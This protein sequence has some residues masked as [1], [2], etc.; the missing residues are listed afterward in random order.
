M[1]N[2]RGQSLV[3]HFLLPLKAHLGSPRFL[4]GPVVIV[5]SNHVIDKWVR[6]K[7]VNA[8]ELSIAL[9]G[10]SFFLVGR[11]S[12]FCRDPFAITTVFYINH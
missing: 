7:V 10:H 8:V 5:V 9:L 3:P 6:E 1:S 11:S 4:S 12:S 2:P